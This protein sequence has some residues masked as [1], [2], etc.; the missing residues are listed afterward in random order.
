MACTAGGAAHITPQRL[1]Q[2]RPVRSRDGARE[3]GGSRGVGER[4]DY[5][6]L[7]GGF[8][9]LIVGGNV[10]VQGAVG[11]ARRLG[12]SPLLVG[13]V[14]VGFGTSM[15]ELVASL[16][17][18]LQGSPAI[19][20]GSIVGSNIANVF[21]IIGIGALICPIAC[22]RE[23]LRRDGAMLVG[24]ALALAAVVL[25]GEAIGRVV[26]IAFL[27]VLFAYILHSYRS[28]RRSQ[29]RKAELKEETALLATE[30]APA[31]VAGTK[32]RILPLPL[33]LLGLAAGI[34]GVVFGADLLVRGAVAVAR[35]L[36][37][38]EAI[39]GVTV[40][41]VGTSLPELV[42]TVIAG[43]R[44]HGE[45]ALGNVIGSNVF[46]ILGILGTTAAVT[47]IPIPEEIARLDLWVML[48]ATVLLLLFGWMGRSINRI[49][50]A[51]LLSAYVGYYLAIFLLPSA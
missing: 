18:A 5:L 15:P 44:G 4:V 12:I 42:T 51:L 48:A 22:D 19:A 7:V 2:P 49:E 24:S 33:Q 34:A 13:L 47:P 11:L 28:D 39:I 14:I 23:A 30:A 40:V 41:A 3:A 27:L 31:D 46:N 25:N 29:R 1:R 10:L 32:P 6:Y 17:A 35:G 50:G 16:T 26:G 36:A 45:V 21:L 43:R 37:I 20:I 38:S 9:L 8:L